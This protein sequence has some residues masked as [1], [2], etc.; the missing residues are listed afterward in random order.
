MRFSSLINITYYYYCICDNINSKKLSLNAF[1][2]DN[3][4][5][6]NIQKYVWNSNAKRTNRGV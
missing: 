4:N 5:M 6:K 1:I 2:K 3:P